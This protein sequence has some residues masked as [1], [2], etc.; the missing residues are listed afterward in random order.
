MKYLRTEIIKEARVKDRDL[1]DW[2][3]AEEEI[4]IY[5]LYRCTDCGDLFEEHREACPFCYNDEIVSIEAY[6][7]KDGSWSELD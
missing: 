1:P 6:K 4:D 7:E 2:A 5:Q 3:Q